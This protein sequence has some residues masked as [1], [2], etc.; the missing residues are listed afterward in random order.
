M[1]AT[2]AAREEG[3]ELIYRGPRVENRIEAQQHIL[4][5]YME[6]GIDGV[7][8]APSHLSRLD[9][10][11]RRASERGA[12]VVVIDSPASTTAMDSFIATDNYAAGALGARL[13]MER[14]PKGPRILLVGHVQGNASTDMREKGF[15]DYAKANDPDAE[16]TVAHLEDGTFTCAI[17]AVNQELHQGRRF[18][19][20]FAVSEMSSIGTLHALRF[21]PKYRI[22]FIA[23]DYTEELARGL[24]TG[25]IDAIIVQ[26]PY[27]MGYLGVKTAARAIRGEPIDKKIVSP[28]VVLTR[29]NVKTEDP[30]LFR[31]TE[32]DKNGYP[33]CFK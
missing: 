31:C 23:F 1:G 13:L 22:P 18:D 14:L 21:K 9:A 5:L 15:C 7:V 16:V 29:D 28:V 3:V 2:D 6:Q 4:S 24:E 26:S 17:S 12:K 32:E 30:R 20:V 11:I 25:C 33:A 19:G 27:S 10:D 8:V